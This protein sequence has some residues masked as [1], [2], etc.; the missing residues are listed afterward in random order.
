MSD[1]ETRVT[2]VPME[3]R[4]GNP[5]DWPPEQDAVL[6]APG[7]HSVLME[8]DRVRVL[9]VIIPPMSKEA[10][11]HHRWPSVIYLVEGDVFLDHDGAGG[12]IFDTREFDEPLRLPVTMWK[13]PEALH[14]A[15]NLSAT[16]PMRL[17]RVEIKD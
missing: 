1:G 17:I 6:A 7:N 3:Y 15:E 14:Y 16:T 13:E 2:G 9:E 4:T 12:I 10:P 5:A 8:N 11:H